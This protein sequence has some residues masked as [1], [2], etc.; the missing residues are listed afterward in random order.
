VTY[1]QR[2][3][4]RLRLQ[5]I[6]EAGKHSTDIGQDLMLHRSLIHPHNV[7]CMRPIVYQLCTQHDTYADLLLSQLHVVDG[8]LVFRLYRFVGSSLLLQLLLCCLQLTPVLGKLLIGIRF[9]FAA[10]ATRGCTSNSLFG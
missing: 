7:S 5:H 2:H 1:Q 8:G 6:L 10:L 4:L 3:Q 9:L